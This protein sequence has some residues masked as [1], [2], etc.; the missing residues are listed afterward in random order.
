MMKEGAWPGPHGP[1]LHHAAP[2]EEEDEEGHAIRRGPA[3]T[4]QRNHTGPGDG[5]MGGLRVGGSLRVT[6]RDI[7]I[8]DL[9]K[10]WRVAIKTFLDD[11]EGMVS[12]GQEGLWLG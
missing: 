4:G 10:C 8:P 3:P 7:H 12:G 11:P 1:E 5:R 9:R 6:V 2:G